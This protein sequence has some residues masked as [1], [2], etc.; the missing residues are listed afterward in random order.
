MNYKEERETL[1][2]LLQELQDISVE[3]LANQELAR[4]C[5]ALE[6]IIPQ[7]EDLSQKHYQLMPTLQYC[8]CRQE[9]IKKEMDKRG[10]KVLKIDLQKIFQ[11]LEEDPQ[12]VIDILSEVPFDDLMAYIDVFKQIDDDELRGLFMTIIDFE[13]KRRCCVL[14]NDTVN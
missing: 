5:A 8:R 12:A 9:Q 14:T 3:K 10:L 11:A 2:E 13:V 6:Q 4:F 7:L 1:A